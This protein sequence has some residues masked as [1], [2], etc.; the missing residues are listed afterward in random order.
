MNLAT[1]R[2]GSDNRRIVK[3][4]GIFQPWKRSEFEAITFA[5]GN[6]GMCSSSTSPSPLLVLGI[7][8]TR[9]ARRIKGSTITLGAV[10]SRNGTAPTGRNPFS[11]TGDELKITSHASSGGKEP[12]L[13]KKRM[14]G[15]S[16][17]EPCPKPWHHGTRLA[18]CSSW[19]LR[20]A[21]YSSGGN[22]NRR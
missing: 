7:N 16:D 10:R 5:R 15:V 4:R 8:G 13:P 21:D 2:V 6:Q 19:P 11:L 3:T 12:T 14:W 18:G 1:S 22:L 17:G 20:F 9:S